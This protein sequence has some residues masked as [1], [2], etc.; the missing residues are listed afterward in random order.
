N[1][2]KISG[3]KV[4]TFSLQYCV[5]MSCKTHLPLSLDCTSLLFIRIVSELFI[6]LIFS[7][8]FVWKTAVLDK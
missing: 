1:Q 5:G 2:R 4:C 3:A 6:F 8:N 7:I